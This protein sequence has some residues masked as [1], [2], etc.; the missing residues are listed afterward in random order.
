MSEEKG[1]RGLLVRGDHG[2]ER[3]IHENHIRDALI[4][5]VNVCHGAA[6]RSGW[7]NNPKTGEDLRGAKNW[8]TLM[9]LQISEI[10]EGFEGQRKNLQDDH[11][12]Q[13]KMLD[14]EQADAIIRLFD[15]IGGM[16]TQTVDALVDK[17][18]YNAQRAD[19][20]PENRVKEGGKQF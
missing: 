5:L 1:N 9:L 14:V 11:L 19:H 10:I 20:K 7:W 4:L 8:H 2:E 17:L 15:S 18:F 13:Y 16:Q 6:A 3:V 12:P